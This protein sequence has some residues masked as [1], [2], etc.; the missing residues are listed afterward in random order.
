V[1]AEHIEFGWAAVQKPRACLSESWKPLEKNYVLG[2]VL[3]STQT[4]VL[5]RLHLVVAF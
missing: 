2:L 4:L 5:R 1:K 3:I